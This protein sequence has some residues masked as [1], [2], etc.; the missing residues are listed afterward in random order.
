VTFTNLQ[1]VPT[2]A[3]TYADA[4][5]MQTSGGTVEAMPSQPQGASFSAAYEPTT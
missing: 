3:L 2:S 4:I 5:E 1:V